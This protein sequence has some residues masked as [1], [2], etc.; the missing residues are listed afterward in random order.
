MVLSPG[1]RVALHSRAR[2]LECISLSTIRAILPWPGRACYLAADCLMSSA[3]TPR[4][5]VNKHPCHRV[6]PES[7][8]VV[9]IA[10]RARSVCFPIDQRLT[11]HGRPGISV[12]A[13]DV[14]ML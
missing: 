8:A 4:I 10:L 3:L 14:L 5:W 12:L 13:S 11:G 2:W 6:D 7:G 9:D 1:D